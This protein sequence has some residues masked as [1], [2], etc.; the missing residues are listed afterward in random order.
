MYYSLVGR[1]LEYE[2]QSFAEYHNIGVLVW[3]ALAG[4]FLSGKCSRNNPA[5]VGSRFAEAGQ[6][7]PFDKENGYEIVDVLREV[8]K[9]ARREPGPRGTR[10]GAG[11]PGCKQCDSRCPKTRAL[12]RQHP[13]RGPSALN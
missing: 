9:T 6:F 3:S 2:F 12:G 4:G 7:V 8:A 1:G 13:R 10:V 5:P 11:A